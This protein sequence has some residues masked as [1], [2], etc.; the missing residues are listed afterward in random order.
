MDHSTDNRS[1]KSKDIKERSTSNG[2]RTRG[3]K[4][5][6]RSRS[7]RSRDVS[8]F[9]GDRV[10]KRS[11]SVRSRDGSRFSG[12]RVQKRSRSVRSRDG[13]WFSGDKVQRRRSRSGRSRDAVAKKAFDGDSWDM[14]SFDGNSWDNDNVKDDASFRSFGSAR[15]WDV[16]DKSGKKA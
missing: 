8:W 10:Q 7:G 9:S 2:V 5:A 6:R 16:V 1:D 15:S 12:D 4:A 3:A 14:N 11:R 13:S